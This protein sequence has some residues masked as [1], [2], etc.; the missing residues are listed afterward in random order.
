[1]NGTNVGFILS[2]FGRRQFALVALGG[3]FIHASLGRG[4]EEEISR[5]ES[6]LLP[7]IAVELVEE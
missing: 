1:M 5:C 7:V 3:E 6:V 4:W 2:P